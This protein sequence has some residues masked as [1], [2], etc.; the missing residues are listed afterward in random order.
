MNKQIWRLNARTKAVRL[1]KN[2]CTS[3]LL[4]ISSL[5]VRPNRSFGLH[6]SRRIKHSEEKIQITRAHFSRKFPALSK[7]FLRTSC[8]TSTQGILRKGFAFNQKLSYSNCFDFRWPV[9]MSC[10]WVNCEVTSG[11]PCNS[12]PPSRPRAWRSVPMFISRVWRPLGY[13]GALGLIYLI[14]YY[15]LS[16]K[17]VIELCETENW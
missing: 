15:Y 10:D 17:I 16:V 8:P 1:A 12:A 14:W 13:P 11:Q 9:V 4:S 6:K 2:R 7:C 5:K 3:V